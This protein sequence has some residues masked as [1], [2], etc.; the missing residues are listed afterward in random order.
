MK[1]L[2][3]ITLV[4]IMLVLSV[5]PALAAGGPPAN[6]GTASGNSDGNQVSF[7]IRTP[8]ALSGTISGI[9][10]DARTVIV[11]VVCGNRLVNPYI[12][13]NVTLQTTVATR[14]LLRNEDGMVTPIAFE[15]LA[16]GQNINSHGTLVDGV[17]TANRITSGALLNCQP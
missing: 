11:T 14:F 5:V 13:Q 3:V 6:R 2:T 8:Y 4:V 9:D 7:G 1:K 10:G 15:D 12:G 17:W 16:V